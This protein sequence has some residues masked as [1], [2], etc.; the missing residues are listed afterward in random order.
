MDAHNCPGKFKDARKLLDGQ[1][2]E[3]EKARCAVHGL[4]RASIA[5]GTLPQYE[6]VPIEVKLGLR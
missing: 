6:C 2:D 1:R 5:Q 4:D 3:V